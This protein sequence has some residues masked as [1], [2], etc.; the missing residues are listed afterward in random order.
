MT[1]F[2]A[3][4]AELLKSRMLDN[5]KAVESALEDHFCGKSE[6]G[7]LALIKKAQIYSLF[8]GGKRIRP[9]L[10]NEVCRSLGGDTRA[11]MPFAVAVEMIHTYSLIHDDLPCMDNDDMR[12]GKP[13]NHKAFGEAAAVLAGDALLTNAFGAA[14]ENERLA[15]SVI[16]SGIKMLSAAAGDAGMIGGQII[17]IESESRERSFEELLQLHSLKT[18]R[19]IEVSAS[20][21]ALSAGYGEGT[22]E[23]TAVKTYAQKIGLAFQAID[24]LLDATSDEQTMGKSLS[25]KDNEKTTFLTFFDIDGV[26]EYAQR[27]TEE[28]IAAVSELENFD[29]LRS[30]AVYL[31]NRNK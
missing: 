9:F 8:G 10:V 23:F 28:A 4:D 29:V 20:L 7:E 18:G 3:Y 15:P 2:K 14:A 25:D 26:R 6:Q 22:R 1:D 16:A 13:S 12:R 27:L 11:S 19:M 31:L 30:L 17:D 21:G 5:A 24:D